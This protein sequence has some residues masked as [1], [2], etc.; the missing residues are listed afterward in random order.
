MSG[1]TGVSR[2]RLPA[3]AVRSRGR[4]G[5]V[6]WRRTG[7]G[8]RHV[9]SGAGPVD[10]R[11][12]DAVHLAADLEQQVAAVLGLV[13][14]VGVAE[15]AAGLL[16]GVQAKAQ[17]GRVDPPVADLAQAPYCRGLRQG[18]CDLRQGL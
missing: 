7:S 4:G 18:V 11:V 5:V 10:Q 13:D 17:T 1:P 6:P 16:I 3:W 12:E 8:G 9:Q 2:S 14:R 15:A